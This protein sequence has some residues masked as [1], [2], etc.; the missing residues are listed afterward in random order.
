MGDGLKWRKFFL[1]IHTL[2]SSSSPC[3]TKVGR[4]ADNNDHSEHPGLGTPFGFKDAGQWE[5]FRPFWLHPNSICSTGMKVLVWNQSITWGKFFKSQVYIHSLLFKSPL[6][7]IL[8]NVYHYEPPPQLLHRTA[9]PFPGSSVPLYS[10]P[11]PY[12]QALG[13]H[14]SVFLFQFCMF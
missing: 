10:Q 8:A 11:L 6:L 7:W 2:T 3:L 5:W 1:L 4:R 9:P 12:S 13:D 14:Q